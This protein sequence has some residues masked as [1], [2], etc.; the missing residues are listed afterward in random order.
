MQLEFHGGL[1][2]QIRSEDRMSRRLT[3]F[4]VLFAVATLSGH[5]NDWASLIVHEWGTFTSIAGEDGRAV[6][7]LPM[8]GPTDLPCFVD[9]FR[10]NLKGSLP[11]TVRMETPVVY[12]YTPRET[13]V[14]VKVQ[15]RQ[16]AVTEWFPKAVVTPAQINA[17]SLRTRGFT[18][19][20]EWA[21]VK[22]SPGAATGFPVEHGSS[23]YYKAR[24][25]DAAPVRLGAQQEKFL[26]YRGVGG[27]Q[28]PLSATV[29]A[30]GTVV[31]TH[32]S[33]EPIGDVILFENRGGAISYQVRHAST[34]RTT[35]DPPPLDESGPPFRELEALL[36]SHGLYPRE[37]RAM[38]ETWRDSWFEEGMR[39]LYLVDPKAVA[40]VV[41]LE[42]SP[43]PAHVE[44]VFVGRM[45]LVTPATREEVE[46]AIIGNDRGTLAKYGRF[47]QPI[48]KR[49]LEERTP[50]DRLHLE[51]RLRSVYASWATSSPTCR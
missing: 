50:A 31:V 32:A 14:N 47:L 43:V 9:R 34:D 45:E 23:H 51:E 6:E 39:L 29:A 48:G 2:R 5:P 11:G 4:V 42:I 18:S 3:P 35:L 13:T 44:R 25:T 41:P 33:G 38:V 10:F 26:F 37:A 8:D 22:V 20:I 1:L 36:V 12:F 40:A 46:A 15:F 19:T 16:G 30:D 21:D 28:P 24:D 7:W 49:L 17:L 27:F